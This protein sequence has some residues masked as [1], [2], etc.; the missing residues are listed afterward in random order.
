MFI[1]FQSTHLNDIIEPRSEQ[2]ILT[3]GERRGAVSDLDAVKLLV[4]AQIPDLQLAV[5]S[6]C[7]HVAIN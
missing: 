5:D 6:R 4:L 2:P 1:A 7:R 3:E